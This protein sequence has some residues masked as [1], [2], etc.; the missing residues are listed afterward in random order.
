M[1]KKKQK[2]CNFIIADNLLSELLK[3]IPEKALFIQRNK[4]NEIELITIDPS[5]D[6]LSRND[7]L[8]LNN[9]N[10]LSIDFYLF[11]IQLLDYE[12]LKFF[13]KLKDEYFINVLFWRYGL[14]IT[15]LDVTNIILQN[16]NGRILSI[17]E[18]LK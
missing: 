12:I 10:L 17:E 8:F 13:N 1:S 16:V 7:L 11:E 6:G 18:I 9:N 15:F 5:E 2:T 4:H 14:P 3:Y